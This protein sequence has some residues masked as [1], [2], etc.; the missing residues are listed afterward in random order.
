MRSWFRF[1][2]STCLIMML[3]A[4]G[5]LWLN[6]TSW[7]MEVDS[8][9]YTQQGYGSPLSVVSFGQDWDVKADEFQIVAEHQTIHWGALFFDVAFALVTLWGIGLLIELIL[10]MGSPKKSEAT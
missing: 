8:T 6:L 2:L 7:E 5:W 9:G 4:S 3:L 10:F 1:H